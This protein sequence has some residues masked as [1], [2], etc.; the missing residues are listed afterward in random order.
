MQIVHACARVFEAPLRV[1]CCLYDVG[2]ID[3]ARLHYPDYCD[4]GY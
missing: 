4:V 2:N 3:M 1:A